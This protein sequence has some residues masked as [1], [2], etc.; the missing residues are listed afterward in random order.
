MSVSAPNGRTP[1]RKLEGKDNT[2]PPTGETD[3]DHPHIL[4]HRRRNG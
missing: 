2:P 3:H 4:T 1:G